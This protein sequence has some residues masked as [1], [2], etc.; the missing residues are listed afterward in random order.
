MNQGDFSLD[1]L[2][3]TWENLQGPS[4]NTIN[5]PSL[6]QEGRIPNSQELVGNG[7]NM[8]L[9]QPSISTVS[10]TS[11]PSGQRIPALSPYGADSME[12]APGRVPQWIIQNPL[13]Q[14]TNSPQPSALPME[15]S[16]PQYSCLQMTLHTSPEV[17]EEVLSTLLV[18]LNKLNFKGL[19]A[20]FSMT[21]SEP[22][23]RGQCPW[24][25][26][27]PQ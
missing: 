19:L 22:H 27:N 6:D 2:N 8:A 13:T 5:Y 10:S 12:V 11:L 1:S 4:Q 9:T 21:R 24:K 14:A 17:H 23:L 3:P 7:Q 25:A 15:H 20:T 18:T 26:L 16:S